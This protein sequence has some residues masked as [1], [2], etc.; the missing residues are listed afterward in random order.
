MRR[1]TA[2]GRLPDLLQRHGEQIA[3]HVELPASLLRR[4]RVL[5]SYYLRYFYSTTSS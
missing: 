5:P 3:E 1:R 2:R 4:L